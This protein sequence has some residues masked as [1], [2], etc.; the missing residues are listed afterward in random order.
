MSRKW[1]ARKTTAFDA[2]A[3]GPAAF[4]S[5]YPL[6]R[7]GPDLPA[8][9]KEALRLLTGFTLLG[10]PV[11]CG[12]GWLAGHSLGLAAAAVLVTAA[13]TLAVAAAR[14][15]GL[16][17]LLQRLP[18]ILV[19][20]LAGVGLVFVSSL[21]PR[22]WGGGAFDL[23]GGVLI[24]V[25]AGSVLGSLYR[26]LAAAYQSVTLKVPFRDLCIAAG[27]L[28]VSL[29]LNA[30][31]QVCPSF[32][33]PVLACVL[34]AGFAGPVVAEYAAWAR[35]NPGV[36]V[37]RVRAFDG[38]PAVAGP[39]E[40]VG[41]I[42]VRAALFGAA[43]FGLGYGLV[44]ALPS[45][46]PELLRLLRPAQGWTDETAREAVATIFGI[47]LVAMPLGWAW[48]NSA[49]GGLRLV[50]PIPAFRIGLD[51]IAVFLTYPEAVHPLAHRLHCRWLRPLAVRLALAAVVVTAVATSAVTP[52]ERRKAALG[53]KPTPAEQTT[54]APPLPLP[55]T[56]WPPGPRF[57]LPED[58]FARR[59]PVGQGPGGWGRPEF[60]GFGG[61]QFNPPP[62]AWNPAPVPPADVTPSR[63]SGDVVTRFALSTM[64]TAVAGPL[65]L[66]AMVVVLGAAV[67]PTYFRHFEAAEPPR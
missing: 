27:A 63:P 28:P 11:H 3:V 14:W 61:G 7:A 44:S 34:A 52:P 37:E 59:G 23:L 22:V 54:P 26:P 41:P 29:G 25:A 20:G 10:L 12:I 35:A 17:D 31:N 51:A 38:L 16:D 36:G 64:A 18:L 4:D 56:P 33:P 42:D 53:E 62:P 32:V 24:I 58:E 15:L 19:L 49:L 50:N 39:R 57:S 5:P 1:T 47:G 13:A 2:A 45:H 30:V 6:F 55:A 65:F 60:G 67:L 46:G 66:Y 48:A 40:R 9:R 8:A 43:V 21:P